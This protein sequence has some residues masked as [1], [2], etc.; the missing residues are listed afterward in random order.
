VAA[1]FYPLSMLWPLVGGEEERSIPPQERPVPPDGTLGAS[2]T[3]QVE[4]TTSAAVNPATVLPVNVALT[5]VDDGATVPVRLVLSGSGKLLAVIP[6]QALEFST[7]Y[8]FAASGFADF[9]GGAV[10]VP[11]VTFRTKDFVAPVYD[12]KKLAFSFPDANGI[13]TLTAPA[14]TLPP[15]STVLVINAGN[16]VVATFTSDNDGAVGV[17]V[18]AELPASISDRLLITIEDPSGNVTTFEKS[19]FTDPA[20]GRTAVGPGGG[21]VVAADGSGAELRIPAG[22]VEEGVV[23]KIEHLTVEE[24]EALFPGESP[25]FTGP[26]GQPLVNQGGALKIESPDAPAFKKE[27]D[28]VFPLPQLPEGVNPKDAYYHVVKRMIGPN[29]NVIYETIDDAFVEGEG[30]EAKLVTASWPMPGFRTAFGSVDAQGNLASNVTIYMALFWSHAPAFIAHPLPGAITGKVQRLK[31]KENDPLNPGSGVPEYEPV[32]RAAVS[33]V[34]QAGSPFF[35]NKAGATIAVSQEDGTFTLYDA[36]YTGGPIE[37][38]ATYNGQTVKARGF[39]VNPVDWATTSLKLYKNIATVNLTFPAT[40]PPPEPPAIQIRVMRLLEGK[41]QDTGGLV[42][43]NTPLVIGFTA[44]NADVRGAQIRGQEYG[45]Q[46]DPLKGQAQALGMDSIINGGFTP[47]EVG[48][49]TVVATAIPAFG[50]PVSVSLTF[51]VI[52]EGGSNNDPLP[53]EPPQV[54]TAKTYPAHKAKGIPVGVLPRVVFSEPVR[55][56]PGSVKLWDLTSGGQVPVTLSGVGPQGPIEDV[57]NLDAV[58]TSLTVVPLTGLAYGS[59]Y[60]LALLGTIEDLDD[61]PKALAVYETEFETFGPQAVLEPGQGETFG[62]AGIVVLGNVAYLVQNLFRSGVLRAFDMTN[63][64]SPREIATARSPVGSIVGRPVDMAGEPG[65]IVV[66]TGP[67]SRSMPSN[68]WVFDVSSVDFSSWVGAVSLAS[69]AS[70]GFINRITVRNDR[71]Y[72]FTVKKGIQVVDLPALREKFESAGGAATGSRVGADLVTDG[73]GWGMENVTTIPVDPPPYEEGVGRSAMLNDLEA[74]EYVAGGQSQTLVVGTGNI[75]LL[76]VNPQTFET[77]YRGRLEASG[78]TLMWGG[79]LALSSVADREVAVVTGLGRASGGASVTA[80]WV[81]ALDDPSSPEVLATLALPAGAQDIL[82][83]DGIAYLGASDRV[84]LV[85]ITDPAQPRLAGEVRGVAGRLGLTDEGLLLSSQYSAFGGESALGGVRVATLKRLLTLR[86]ASDQPTP[87]FFDPRTSPRRTT[88]KIKVVYRVIPS[89]EPAGEVKVELLRGPVVVEEVPGSFDGIAGEAIWPE[90]SVVE[91]TQRYYAQASADRGTDQE[92]MSAQVPLP[93]SDVAITMSKDREYV[94]AFA[95]D[96][97]GIIENTWDKA[98]T[99]LEPPING[100]DIKTSARTFSK[101]VAPLAPGP[102]RRPDDYIRMRIASAGTLVW[103]ETG[104]EV[105]ELTVPEDGRV[106]AKL[107]AKKE[108]APLT[109]ERILITSEYFFDRRSTTPVGL[110]DDHVYV[111]NKKLTNWIQDI[112]LAAIGRADDTY[113]GRVQEMVI[114]MTPIVGDGAAI[115]GEAINAFDPETDVNKG[116]ALLALMGVAADILDPS[117]ISGVTVS[118]V[119]VA[120]RQVTKAAG[121]L[122]GLPGRMWRA[123]KSGGGMKA[124]KEYADGTCKLVLAGGKDF[125]EKVFREEADELAANRFFKVYGPGD[126]L[127]LAQRLASLHQT[128][129]DPDAVRAA[130]RAL[131]DH[132]DELGNVIRLSD[133]AVHGAVKFVAQA[134]K[135]LDA[136]AREGLL[137]RVLEAGSGEA[138]DVLKFVKE[139][140]S[141]KSVEGLAK[142][143]EKAPCQIIP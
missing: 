128:F 32:A 50:S 83:R 91:P 75:G 135:D 71:V 111:S 102:I 61:P 108:L 99:G 72:A 43:V 53:N 13:V 23:L 84:I 3:L 134:G 139:T 92:L 20:T 101:T 42:V 59:R 113:E 58:V 81:V 8:R 117:G 10:S 6:Q 16:G 137:R 94:V 14:G 104:S 65:T 105:I 31:W 22:A 119:R 112:A 97:Q 86:L 74:G 62:S 48:T 64:A 52:A 21:T 89:T 131:A 49:Y 85:N 66:A 129:G 29:Q 124:V 24:I 18:P 15:G 2:P 87:V 93:I 1:A 103:T 25:D 12:P 44:Q 38:S 125:G 36:R 28:L 47:T 54:I 41:R 76:I 56:I 45:V 27:V 30:A 96:G 141:P 34:D 77:V 80:L 40:P 90:G 142:Y 115:L 55:R 46:V 39:Q 7:D 19:E 73:R 132:K 51:R 127:T 35:L 140:P 126:D 57:N 4:I 118:I 143:L 17:L 110:K 9:F 69:S 114:G 106:E 60:Q 121:F 26:D 95:A 88:E 33:G 130:L 107:Q 109:V 5:K 68:L 100:Y 79:A 63:P 122:K 136:V 70:D 116:N 98:G 123:L 133:D 67:P 37:V 11:T 120:F 78:T 82:I 138:E